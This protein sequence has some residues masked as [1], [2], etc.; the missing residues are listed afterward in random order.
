MHLLENGAIVPSHLTAAPTRRTDRAPFGTGQLDG[1]KVIRMSERLDV[2]PV[3]PPSLALVGA[4]TEA[5]VQ[6]LLDGEIERWTLV[7][8]TLRAPLEALRSKYGLP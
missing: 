2:A 7:D 6:T 4:A 8:E 3:A 5:R 1:S